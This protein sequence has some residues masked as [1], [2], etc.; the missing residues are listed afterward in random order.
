[1]K[2]YF[3]TNEEKDVM[4]SCINGKELTSANIELYNK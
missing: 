3:G 1:M 2:K 4:I